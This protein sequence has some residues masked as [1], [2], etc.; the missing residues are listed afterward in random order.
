MDSVLDKLGEV[1]SKVLLKIEKISQ[2]IK[3]ENR[4]LG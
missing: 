2:F 3:N 1:E 4:R